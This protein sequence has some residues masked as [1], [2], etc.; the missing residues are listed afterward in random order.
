M[1]LNGPSRSFTSVREKGNAPKFSHNSYSFLIFT[2]FPTFPHGE[3]RALRNC[4][5]G[6]F[7]ERACLPRGTFPPWGKMKGGIYGFKLRYFTRLS[8]IHKRNKYMK[9]MQTQ[10]G[11]INLSLFSNT[12]I[13]EYPAILRSSYASS[14]C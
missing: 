1:C 5:V 9:N 8:V 11:I 7:S 14:K 10:N 13:S 6:N 3:G 2:P 12:A 4:Q